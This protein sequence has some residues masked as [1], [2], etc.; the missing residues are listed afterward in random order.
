MNAP[1]IWIIFPALVAS[2]AFFFRR[3]KMAV[4]LTVTMITLL[5]ALFA[6]LVPISDPVKI[7]PW[8]FTVIDR[9]VFAGRLF[10]VEDV[11][12]LIL[13][14]TYLTL[15]FFFSASLSARV[16]KLFIPIGLAM[17]AML[18]ASLSV[19]PFLYASLFIE[20]AVLIGIP[21]LSP[22]GKQVER[23]VLRYLA[24]LS[25]GFP[26]MLV[27]GWLLADLVVDAPDPAELLPG[28]VFL[29]LGFVFLLAI[30]PL[31]TWI[32]V[33]LEQV[34]PY[35]TVFFLSVFPT[36]VIAILLRFVGQYPWLLDFDV[37]QF[38]GVLMM[39]TGGLWAAFQR[40]LGRLLGYAI[41]LEI[42]Y[43]LVMISQPNGLPI[44]EAMFL[45]RI[46]AFGVWALSLSLI[47]ERVGDFRFRSVQ[48]LG[49]RIP[50]V[51]LGVLVSHFSLAGFPLLAS[52]P[53][54]LALWSQLAQTSS[55]IAL[56]VLLSSV[57]LLTGGLRSLA[58]FV[59]G[60]EELP[61]GEDRIDLISQLLLLLGIMAIVMVGLFPQLFSGLIRDFIEPK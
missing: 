45:P 2:I 55:I 22:P 13:T 6:W 57:G 46:L 18:V 27:G 37:I 17:S 52:F 39:F 3:W 28:L 9:L 47:R 16:S 51:V 34:H 38:L 41:I 49:R 10:V 15:T 43:S 19:R 61:L 14:F 20:V 40:N 48:G 26:F 7:G 1:V 24:F 12:R 21:L 59:M 58:V 4:T 8:T 56:L 5:L 35:P 33:L 60:S 29:G 50:L 53:Y 25:F 42:G 11:D 23:G 44:Y 30:F 32:P 36:I 31:N 54:L